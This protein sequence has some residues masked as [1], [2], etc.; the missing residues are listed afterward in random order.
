QV[1]IARGE[2]PPDLQQLQLGIYLIGHSA[3]QLSGISLKCD[4]GEV[5]NLDADSDW[6]LS[7]DQI[8]FRKRTS[9]CDTGRCLI[10]DHAPPDTELRQDRDIVDVDIGEGL[11]MALPLVVWSDGKTT[12]P[13]VARTEPAP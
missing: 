4:N 12:F 8:L 1:V 10:V 9:P 7:Q 6:Q 3:I 11:Q 13:N 5:A 2:V